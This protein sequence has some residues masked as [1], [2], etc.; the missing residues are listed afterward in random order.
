MLCKCSGKYIDIYFILKLTFY[1]II[2]YLRTFLL[3]FPLFVYF[4]YIFIPCPCLKC[5]LGGFCAYGTRDVTSD[6]VSLGPLLAHPGLCYLPDVYVY[7]AAPVASSDRLR[8][9]VA[10]SSSL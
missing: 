8:V 9:A 1:C 3:I 6:W 4:I 7:T 10:L 5:P 2:L